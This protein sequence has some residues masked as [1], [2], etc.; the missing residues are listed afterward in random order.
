MPLS[1]LLFLSFTACASR[2][3]NMPG[4]L[5]PVAHQRP[6]AMHVTDLPEADDDAEPEPEP[7]RRRS[8]RPSAFGTAVATA[9]EKHLESAPSGFRNDCSGFV[10]AAYAKAGH[11]IVGSTRDLWAQA[12]EGGFVSKRPQLGDVAFF[13]NTYDRNRNGRRDDPLTHVGVV[14]AIDANGTLTLAHAGTS[15]GR[16]RLQMNLD[17]PD[18]R[19]G[20]DG[21]VYNDWLR[22]RR[23]GESQNAA[24]LA[25]QLFKGFA[26]FGPSGS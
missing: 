16:A 25:G 3:L 9:A 20:P 2:T 22:A 15:K 19:I 21:S 11:P 12:R 6:A 4:P 5:G 1:S 10:M 17:H 24:L 26:R 18:V 13:D 14:I 8:N 7:Q 23:K